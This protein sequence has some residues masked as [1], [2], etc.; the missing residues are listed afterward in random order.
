[1]KPNER[2]LTMTKY[3]FSSSHHAFTNP[4]S[5]TDSQELACMI[6]SIASFSFNTK[7]LPSACRY[8]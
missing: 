3:M 4:T 8:R 7:S 2:T 5:P 1:M 6:L